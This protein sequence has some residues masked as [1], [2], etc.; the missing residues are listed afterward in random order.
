MQRRDINGESAHAQA[1]LISGHRSIYVSGQVAV[2]SE[3]DAIGTDV[4]T[5]ATVIFER[6]GRF[7]GEAGATLDDVVKITTFLTN[8]DDYAAFA[9]ARSQAFPHRKPASSTV[10]VSALSRPDFLLEIEAVAA[11][12]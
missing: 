3:G 12:A 1:V 6:I 8:M 5:Q 7:L 11:I 4:E 2:D 9:R 10:A